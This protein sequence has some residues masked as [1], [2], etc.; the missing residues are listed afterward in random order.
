MRRAA[1]LL[2][3]TGCGLTTQVRPTPKGTLVAELSVGGPAAVV[4]API[5]LPLSALG[6]AWGVLD[7]ADL[8]VHTHLTTLAAAKL[9]GLDVGTAVAALQQAGAVPALTIG[10]RLYLFTDFATGTLGFYEASLAAS[11][12]VGRFRPFVAV[13]T[14]LDTQALAFDVAPAL[15]TEIRFGRF[16]LV[17]ELKWYAPNR[18]AR[19]SSVPWLSPFG[20]GAIGL[21]LGGRYAVL[22]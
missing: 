10:T 3:V 21:V 18:N 7:R 13:A 2:L 20:R 9:F 1:L 11:W 19:F 8:S 6:V 22:Q 5:P 15:G 14:Q 16:T 12:D 17:A 4:G